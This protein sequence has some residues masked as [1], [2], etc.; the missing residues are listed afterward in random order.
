V[1]ASPELVI[2][3]GAALERYE[4]EV[5][6]A[7][8]Q[9]G[10]V[11]VTTG[12]ITY[13]LTLSVVPKGL[14]EVYVTKDV[15][16]ADEQDIPSCVMYD[17]GLS[18]NDTSRFSFDPSNWNV[19]QTV[20]IQVRRNA[21]TYQGSSTT[22][23]LHAV[24]SED[25]DWQSPF[26][27]PMRV[28]IT[29][30]DECTKGA[31]KY[32]DSLGIRKCRCSEGFY[33]EETDP[34]FCES[35]TKCSRCPAGMICEFHQKLQEASLKKGNYRTS[36][37]SLNVANCPI[38]AACIGNARAG[39]ALCIDGHE[40][41]FCMVCTL[42]GTSRYEWSGKSCVL[43]DGGQEWTVYGVC[44][45]LG[46]V[47]LLIVA[48]IVRRHAPNAHYEVSKWEDFIG[49]ATSKYKIVTKFLQASLSV[50][51]FR[52]APSPGDTLL[53]T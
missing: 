1:P 43:C 32:D 31:Q 16:K 4:S 47:V 27:R 11:D 14:V 35:A 49:R 41:P 25:P 48:N 52:F 3:H 15:S 23:F 7:V 42:N 20:G 19:P 26:L 30:D 40:G 46:I 36:A 13:N 24:Q 9:E 29:D 6:T 50:R 45:F 33:V 37:T 39:D 2:E 12:F 38:A 17:D 53:S 5:V 8:T 34:L 22:R 51:L 21:T 10:L 44:L 18:V 28:T